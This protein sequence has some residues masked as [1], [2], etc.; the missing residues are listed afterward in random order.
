LIVGGI[1]PSRIANTAVAASSEAPP[2]YRRPTMLFGT[3]TGTSVPRTSLMAV[4]SIESHSGTPMPS[5]KTASTSPGST[6]ASFSASS[7]ARAYCL[8]SGAGLPWWK[9]SLVAP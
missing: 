7:I 1:T 8:P 4:A 9:A 6:P 3:V 2:A 5:A